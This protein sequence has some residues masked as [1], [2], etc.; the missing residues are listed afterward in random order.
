MLLRSF[1]LY[2]D[3]NWHMKWTFC[4]YLTFCMDIWLFRKS[5]NA[6]GP[7]WICQMWVHRALSKTSWRQDHFSPGKSVWRRKKRSK[8]WKLKMKINATT[9]LCII[10]FTCNVF[11]FHVFCVKHIRFIKLGPQQTDQLWADLMWWVSMAYFLKK[12]LQVQCMNLGIVVINYGN[13]LKCHKNSQWMPG[14]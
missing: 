2:S 5:F 8:E 4:I 10:S 11:G 12:S 9:N 6:K 14:H 1:W 3:A 13:A 7:N